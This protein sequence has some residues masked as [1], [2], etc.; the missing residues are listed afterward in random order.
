MKLVLGSDLHGHLPPVP[1]CDILVLAG[2]ILPET[3]QEVFIVNKLLPWLDRA[4]AKEI[5]ATWGNHD[6]LPFRRWDYRS[7]WHLLVD[8]TTSIMGIKFH[9]TPWCRPVGRWAWQ[10]PENI[11]KYIYSLI[12]D[13]TD[14]LI[15]HT[16]PYLMCDLENKHGENCGS[17]A[18]LERMAQLKELKLLVCGHIHEARGSQDKVLN[19][20]SVRRRLKTDSGYTL[21]VNPWTVIEL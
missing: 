1:P 16:P 19:V 10:A 11:L 12:P 4:L 8:Q 20:S 15:S 18:L 9:G 21:Y 17:R 6:H 5:V 7:R 2:D 3:E 13:D 14:I